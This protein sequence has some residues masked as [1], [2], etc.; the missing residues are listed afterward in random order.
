MYGFASGAANAWQSPYAT[1]AGGAFPSS[2]QVTIPFGAL[3]GYYQYYDGSGHLQTQAVPQ[4]PTSQA[5]KVR[6]TWAADL[7]A[8]SFQ[9][10]SFEV[11]ISNWT[12]TGTN[13][14]YYVAGPGSRRIEDN[15]TAVSYSGTWTPFTG[16]Y[17]GSTIHVAGATG[18][19]VNVSYTESANHQLFLGTRLLSSGGTVSIAIDGAA[20]SAINL[21]LSGEDV[22]ARHSLGTIDAG[23]HTLSITQTSAG[24]TQFW[25]DFLEI[26]YPSTT[27]PDFTRQPQ[28]ALAT[29]WDTYHSQSLP[30]E[31]TAWLIN[32]LGFCGRVDHYVGALWFYELVRTGTQYATVSVGVSRVASAPAL[33]IA[34]LKIDSTLIDHSLLPNDTPETLALAFALLI[35]NGSNSI[36]ASAS[37]ATLTITARAMG[38][39][40]NGIGLSLGPNNVAL[41]LSSSPIQ[42]KGGVDGTSFKLDPTDSLQSALMATTQGWCTDLSATPRI[43]RAA[44]DWHVAYFK[45]LTGYGIEAVAAFS[46]E[47]GNGDPA[48]QVGIAQRY[49]DGS[50][51]IVNT[52][53]VQTNFS[54]AA[55]AYWEQVYLDMATIQ[56]Q[57]GMAPYL[58]SGEVQWWYL[59]K[60][61]TV[62]NQTVDSM[63]FYDAYSKQ[64]F[65]AQYGQTM[66]LIQGNDTPDQ[67][68][69]EMLF[70]PALIGTYTATIRTALQAQN[71]GCR[72]EVLYPTDVNNTPLNEVVNFPTGDWT[73]ANL[74]CLKTESF[75]FTGSYRLDLSTTS[76]GVSAAKGFPNPQRSHLVGI[77]DALSSWMKEVDLAQSQG[78][79]SVVL[80]ALDQYCLIGYP[81]PPFIKLV[82]SGRQG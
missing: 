65:L 77:S 71:A 59:P 29:D 43:N 79:E 60:S 13:R 4:I 62:D 72:Y 20:A 66:A 23:S 42:L 80:W 75:T 57:A 70:L 73:P 51:V 31:R 34:E 54:P 2:Y 36:W 38:T 48:D 68:P 32:K 52:P 69:N 76:I 61:I 64:Q 12:V 39:A 8:T 3:A 14:S 56:V 82:R 16:N 17:S 18:A 33:S 26:V 49:W 63:T 11:S 37:G 6:W 21:A 74:N 22:L 44:W 40:G 53:A 24:S 35:N 41:G 78:L 47:L 27:L 7:Q 1:F 81:P 50:P 28:L 67:H 55:L 5:R 19:S 45:A 10:T 25:F 58:Q 30:A 9:R 46:T 15:D